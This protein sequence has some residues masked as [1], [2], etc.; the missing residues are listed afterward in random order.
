[1]CV[2]GGHFGT[3]FGETGNCENCA[4]ACMGAL[5]RRCGRVWGVNVFPAAFGDGE[6]VTRWEVTF[7]YFGRF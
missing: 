2:L 6:K 3:L 1:M 5:L 4:P 7:G